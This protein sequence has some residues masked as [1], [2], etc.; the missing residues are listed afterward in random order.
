LI[1]SQCQ[2]DHVTEGDIF[3]EFVYIEDDDSRT[4]FDFKGIRDCTNS[5]LKKT[6][7]LSDD[8]EPS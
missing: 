3:P 7:V 5:Q 1:L 6:D 8:L 2:E 4:S